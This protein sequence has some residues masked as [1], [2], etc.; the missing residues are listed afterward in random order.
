MPC[1][2]D[3]FRRTTMRKSSI[4]SKY[5]APKNSTT[6]RSMAGPGLSSGSD[7]TGNTSPGC[8]G[9]QQ[10]G[11]V[12]PV[13]SDPDESPGPA[14]E[15]PVVE[16]FGAGYFELMLDLRMVVRRNAPCPQGIQIA[17][18]PRAFD[19]QGGRAVE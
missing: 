3:A 13:R 15:R 11:D 4:S 5:P 6:G 7:L 19:F 18:A 17:V 8:F 10:P 2:Q 14:I 16:F 1:G 12:F 9:F